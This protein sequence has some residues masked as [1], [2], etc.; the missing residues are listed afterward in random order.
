MYPMKTKI[1]LLI[2]FLTL[3]HTSCTHVADQPSTTQEVSV[4]EFISICD[5]LLSG[6][7]T[8]ACHDK[9]A[10]LTNN[11]LYCRTELCFARL[12][13]DQNN[14]EIC[15]ELK[16]D[17]QKDM[18]Y[19]LIGHFLGENI[20]NPNDCSLPSSNFTVNACYFRAAAVHQNSSIC[21]N[22]TEA[23]TTT[24]QLA[25]ADIAS[26]L[27]PKYGG[28]MGLYDFSF[29]DTCFF[30]FARAKAR[31]GDISFC[32]YIKVSYLRDQCIE[33]LNMSVFQST[34]ECDQA[35][36]E[37]ENSQYEIFPVR[38]CESIRLNCYITLA[39]KTVNPAIC[40]ALKDE[41]INK[42]R[43]SYC[44]FKQAIITKNISLCDYG[45]HY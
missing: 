36:N 14:F 34:D 25:L 16:I 39:Q 17:S 23:E 29:N 37:C 11:S 18:C 30:S 20:T 24:F 40:N 12:A 9:L 3:F 5:L 27:G 21:G 19:I 38:S 32:K 41:G 35:V 22:I 31:S 42:N 15:E 33:S 13:Y 45:L 1:L 28:G 43:R 4:D 2:V 10:E 6:I 7:E 26:P 44:L 8:N